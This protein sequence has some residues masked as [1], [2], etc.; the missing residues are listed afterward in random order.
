[1]AI[2]QNI[3]IGP[4]LPWNLELEIKNQEPNVAHLPAPVTKRFKKNA[5]T[6]AGAKRYGDGDRQLVRK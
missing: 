3:G 1:V 2:S 5:P 4:D 6:D